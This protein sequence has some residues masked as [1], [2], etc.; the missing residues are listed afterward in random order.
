MTKKF[1]KQFLGKT[2]WCVIAFFAIFYTANAV[3]GTFGGG[4][5]QPGTPYIIQDAADL[6]AVRSNLSAHYKLANDIDLTDYLSEGGA[7]F[8]KWSNSRWMPLGNATT[9]FTGSFNGDGYKITGL[10]I[11]RGPN[12]DYVGLFGYT[13]NGASIDNLGV[14]APYI[15]ADEYVGILVGYNDNA[16]ITN[17]YVTGYVVANGLAGVLVGENLGTISYCYA[18]GYIGSNWFVGGLVGQ[19]FGT[20]THC[21]AMAEVYGNS[22]VG[23]F[24]G[25]NNI[26]AAISNCYATGKTYAG[27]FYYAKGGFAGDNYATISN[28]FYDYETTEQGNGVGPGW[29]SGYNVAGVT[30]KSTAEMQTEATFTAAGWD[31]DD[32]WKICENLSYPLFKWHIVNCFDYNYCSGTGTSADPYLICNAKQLDNVR[33]ALDKHYKLNNDIDLTAY[34]APGG[35]GYAKWGA[36]GWMP[37]GNEITNFSGKF[38]GGGFK[39]T[40]LWINR[41]G[42]YYIGLFGYTQG[43][44]IENLGVEIAAAGIKGGSFSGGLVGENISTTISN[45]Y[46]IGNVTGDILVGGL[47]GE[48]TFAS[49]I[50]NCYAIGD[51]TGTL[52]VGGLVGYN[53]DASPISN[54]YAA[55]NVN[56]ESSSAGGLVGYNELSTISNCYFDNEIAGGIPGVADNVLS[57]IDITGKTTAEMQQQA[58]FSGWDFDDIWNIFE[59]CSYPYLQWQPVTTCLDLM[60][61]GGT[62]AWNNPYI[63]CNPKQLDLVRLAFNNS[64]YYYYK[65]NNDIDLTDYLAPG[66]EGYAKW[67]AEGW[68]PLGDDVTH[69]TGTFNGDGHKI[70]GLWIDRS[71][72]DYVG[73]FGYTGSATIE[74]LGVEVTAAGIQGKNNVGGLAG[75]SFWTGIEKCYATGA[76]TG[77]A[78]VGGLVGQ[79]NDSYTGNCYSTCAVTG[80]ENNIGGLVG[81]NYEGYIDWCYA[82]GTVSGSYAVGGLAGTNHEGAIYGCFYDYETTGQPTG[83]GEEIGGDTYVTGKSTIRMKQQLTFNGWNFHEKWSICEGYSYPFLQ[84]QTEI[85]CPEVTFCGGT[86]EVGSPYLICNAEQLNNVRFALDKH[87]K[88]ANN[89]DLTDYLAPGGEGYTKWDDEGWLP[90]GGSFMYFTGTFNGAGHKITGLWIDRDE[91]AYVGLF[92]RI[93]DANIDSLGVEIAAA[94]IKGYESV[95]G[96]VGLTE[97]ATISNCYAT[98]YA[99]GKYNVGGLAG[100][101]GGTI[102]NCYATG[103]VNGYHS[104]GGLAGAVYG[105]IFNC[106]ATGDV[107]GV[108]SEGFGGLLG[109]ANGTIYNCYATGDVNGN[110]S[111]GGLLGAGGEDWGVSISNCYATGNVHG[112]TYAGGLV[113]QIIGT[114]SN[115]YAAGSATVTDYEAGGLVG[116]NWG[117]IS[118]SF[119]DDDVAGGMPGVGSGDDSGVTGK[120]TAQMQQQATFTGWD[121][122]DIWK[123]CEN[124]TYPF[125]QWQTEI[126]CEESSL[127]CGGTGTSTAPYLICTAEQLDKVR[128]ALDKHFKLKNDIDLTAYL[129]DGGAG[130]AK[131]GSAGWEPLGDNSTNNNTTRFT[132]SFNGAGHKITGLW[133]NRPTTDNVG[134]FG[135]TATGS[136]IDS[137]GVEI[138]AA[139]ITGNGNIGGLVGNISYGTISNCYATGKVNGD[140][141]VGGLVGQNFRGTISNCYATGNVTG[142]EYVGGLVGD[143]DNDYIS[144]ISNCYATGNVTGNEYVGGLV[145]NHFMGTIYNCFYDSQ[146]S[147]Q[148]DNTGKGIPKTTAQM[149]QQTTFTDAGWDFTPN[150]GIWTICEG[151][152]YPLFQWQNKNCMDYNFCGGTGT[153]TDPYLICTAEQL[154]KVRNF[155]DKH[156]KLNNDIDLTAY[157]SDGGAG[158]A[159]WGSAGWEPI[160]DNSTH[161]EATQFTGSFNGDGHK[162]TGLWI[163]RG[164]NDW[165]GLFGWI[166][167]ATIKNLGVEIATGNEVKGDV[168]VGGLVGFIYNSSIENCYATGSVTG[169]A[170]IGGLAG[171]NGGTISNCYATGSVTGTADIGGL[172]G[173]NGGTISNCYATGDVT[174]TDIYVGGL[175]GSIGVGTISNCYATGKVEG[176]SFVGGLVGCSP[177]TSSSI[178]NCYA[179]GDVTGT[180]DFVGGLLGYSESKISNCFYDY[181]INFTLNGVGYDDTGT[182]GVTG[183][184]TAEMKV[185]ATFTVAGW[186]FD[187]IWKICEELTYPFFQWQTDIECEE[188]FCGGDGS[189]GSPY[190]ICNAQ[191][192]DNV[193]LALNKHFK[194]NNDID[195]TDYLA[196]GGEG[197]TQ[198]GDEGWEPIGEGDYEFTGTFNGAGY[199]IT[200]LWIDRAG[201]ERIG[202]FGSIDDGAII[203]SLGVEIAAAGII[204]GYKVGGLVGENNDGTITNCYVIGNLT[205]AQQIGGLVG[206]NWGTISNCYFTG[207]VTG[208]YEQAGGLVGENLYGTISNCYAIGNVTGENYVGGLVGQ[209]IG[210]STISN[211]YAAGNVTGTGYVGGFVGRGENITYCF[212]DINVAGGAP[213]VGYGSGTGVTGKATA[214]MQQQSTFTG[215]DFDDIWKI[216]EDLTY[217][218]FQW[219][220]EITC[221]VP[222]PDKIVTFA[223]DDIS[224]APQTVA[225]GGL[226]I[227]PTPAPER[228]GYIFG[229]WFTD[230]GTF[231]NEWNFATCTVTQDTTLW[232]KWL[233]T[234]IITASSLTSF[235]ALQI[236]YTQPAAQT[237]TITNAGTG[238]VTLMQPV[239]ANYV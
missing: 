49:T 110:N 145:G 195:L 31:F 190:L 70:T 224:I 85:E 22:C 232:A 146:T 42:T 199:K 92:G 170:E 156:F 18:T 102:F 215:W 229:G 98:G 231:A 52:V 136:K 184:T 142:N 4:N 228:A 155:L 29:E 178:S 125:L 44:F 237:V 154:D 138:A 107:T 103:N 225:H 163:N 126:E 95:G 172:V 20:I 221:D 208:T 58:T 187:D 101:I 165:V 234:Y 128:L 68:L 161:S 167:G 182:A 217:P 113:G 116:G 121:F 166:T 179:T 40:G 39:I 120:T 69:F 33:L 23:G 91:M 99:N 43:S 59:D 201:S 238:S 174:G 168:Y 5:G 50:S 13:N 132:G 87:Y 38:N 108:G 32:T 73:L 66:G 34:L 143:N 203:D 90:I 222:E 19:N 204:G 219:Q 133:I 109:V 180:G 65:L 80:T 63:I 47:V 15:S 104:A 218:F 8:A 130:F 135:Y 140:Y 175:A 157:L 198:W 60:F 159:K 212:Y 236:P 235:G 88:L 122:D 191:Q 137:L 158:Q 141:L 106:Y 176:T 171:S 76:V 41:S 3:N 84:W 202:L 16:S 45:C 17:C 86:G 233:P 210:S 160:G 144:H 216:C 129:S 25:R 27:E 81:M 48:N 139:G 30:K 150:T 189:A 117:T 105:T 194:L 188:L 11:N 148:S 53:F 230:N 211:C 100:W 28:C 71:G 200:G 62:G 83:V 78:F 67:G 26:T 24:V 94:G 134:L 169:T 79:L 205:D 119:F 56:G 131:W 214:E 164:G 64:D 10:R 57:T 89:I 112:A 123:I 46:V 209:N 35:A 54:C 147:G 6:D 1:T 124:E 118:N 55:G 206:G 82:A 2:L 14:E 207:N 7:G 193:R 97:N 239:S 151:L 72:T 21:Y 177:L 197:Y 153:P 51:V 61:C 115:C 36:A 127:F 220:T 111:S 192:L 196:I 149:K 93:E 181:T 185:G 183:K 227:E 74:N 223:G 96:L 152:S 173:H 162:I 9:P 37:L 114:I 186:D 213:G 226:A 12:L 75:Y 77:N